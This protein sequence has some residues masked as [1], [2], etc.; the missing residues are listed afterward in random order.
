MAMKERDALWLAG[1]IVVA[2]SADSHMA[3]RQSGDGPPS[4]AG[5]GSAAPKVSGSL[6]DGT[7]LCDQFQAGRCSRKNCDQGA[8][9]CG[10][11]LQSG[12]VC[13]SYKH[14]GHACDSRG[15]A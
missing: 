7:R 12:R 4:P 2:P 13:G 9:R 14:G 11:V 1:S 6:R 3:P 15:K 5:K 8:H 10:R